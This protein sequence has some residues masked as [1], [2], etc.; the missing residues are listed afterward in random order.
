MSTWKKSISNIFIIV[1]ITVSVIASVSLLVPLEINAQVLINEVS[2]VSTPEWVEIYNS[3]S[4]STPLKEY[5]I[6]F[7]SDSQ[8]LIFCE[9]ENIG[10]NEYKIIELTSSWLANTGDV[11]SLKNGD[12]EIDKIGYGSGYSLPKPDSVLKYITRSPDGSSSWILSSQSSR[13]GNIISFNCPTPTPTPLPTSLPTPLPTSPPEQGVFK[14]S[15]QINDSKDD[16]GNVLNSVQ[17]FV[18]GNYIHHEDKEIIYFF[19]GHECYADV[20]CGLGTHTISMRKSG[21]ESWEDTQ[22]FTAG[23]NFNVNP[24]LT[25]L[26]TSSPT[27][28]PTISPKSTKTP[29]ALSTNTPTPTDS[30]A[31]ESAV[32]GIRDI[33]EEKQDFTTQTVEESK[34]NIPVLPIVLI[35]GGLCFI[36]FSIFSMIRNG[37][38]DI[39]DY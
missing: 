35:I 38:K 2:P 23:S 9:N 13:Q 31:S 26:S 12:D 34:K 39:K 30:L 10:A 8:N 11:L 32:L 20:D 24:V 18:D 29:I 4:N 33:K 27:P 15:Y 1:F 21:Y 6:N 3:G 22:N 37:K 16:K 17:I 19:N 5:S 14:S 25:R 28:S 7:G 36:A